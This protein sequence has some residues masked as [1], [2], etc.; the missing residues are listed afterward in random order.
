MATRRRRGGPAVEEPDGRPPDPPADP[1]SAART[2]CLRALTHAP[3]TRAELADLLQRRGVP[4]DVAERVL[5]RFGDV[6]L[7]DDAAFAEAWVR[8][9]HAG[10]GLAGRALADELRRR[11]VEQDTV[12]DAVAGLDPLTE[13][14]TA[15]TLVRRRLATMGRLAPDVRQRRLVGMLARKGYGAGV[16]YRVVREECAAA[17][18]HLGD[19]DVPLPD[20]A[21]LDEAGLDDESLH[22]ADD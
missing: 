4:G 19:D 8:T 10:R 6:G 5:S 15:R 3:R 9:R 22:A 7:I 2:I 17:A 11:G 18:H 21:G 14:E 1:E 16:A 20:D 13:E 12:Q